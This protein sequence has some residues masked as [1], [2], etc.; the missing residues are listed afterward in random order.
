M[1]FSLH[2]K[3]PYVYKFLRNS[4]LIL[5]SA[6]LL[7]KLSFTISPH[8]EDSDANSYLKKKAQR[9][10]DKEL[11]VNMLL[12]EIHI[13]LLLTYKNGKLIGSTEKDMAT[14]IHYFIII[15]LFSGNKDIVGF[16]LAKKCQLKNC[17]CT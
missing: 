14:T 15:S 5:P 11:F 4:F 13:K 2:F 8:L 10:E 3:S 17:S 12:D 6:K 7:R 16:V 9:L 1:A